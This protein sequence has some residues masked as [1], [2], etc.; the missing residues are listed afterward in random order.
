M[1]TGRTKQGKR[2]WKHQVQPELRPTVWVVS[3]AR[4]D[5]SKTRKLSLCEYSCTHIH[6]CDTLHTTKRK[7]VRLVSLGSER[8]KESCSTGIRVAPYRVSFA[9]TIIPL[10]SRAKMNQRVTWRTNHRSITCQSS[11][12]RGNT[13]NFQASHLHVYV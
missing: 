8:F 12:H 11:S 2:G 4:N 6:I 1:S 7:W 3:N 13:F 9:Y 10:G 5:V